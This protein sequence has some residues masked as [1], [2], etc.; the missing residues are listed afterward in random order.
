MKAG[1]WQK[2]LGLR[3]GDNWKKELIA[4][5]VSYFSVVYIVMVNANI[6]HDAGMPLKAAMIGTILTSIAGCLLMAFGGKSPIVVV[7]GMGINAFFTY[8]LV[9]SMKLGWQEALMV[10]AVTGVLFTI[11]TFTSLYR[12]ISEAI[13][14]NLQHGITVGIGLFL[15]FI[16]LQKS[17]IVIAHQTTFVTIG[18]FSDPSVIVA[19]ITLLLALILFIRGVQGGLLI[20]ILAGTG[21]AYLLGAVKPAKQMESGPIFKQYGT[22]FGHLSWSGFGSLVF[23]IAVFLLLLIVVFENIGLIAAQTRMI[24]RPENFKGSLRAL[25]LTNIFAGIFGSSPVVA[26]AETTAGIAAGGRTGLSSLVSAVLFGATFFFIPL[27][28]YIPD[29]AI[30][31]ILIVIGGLMVQNVKEM[32]FGDLT[33]AFPAFLIMVMIPFTYS[34]VDGMAFGFIAYP[35]VKLARGKGREVSPVLYGIAALFVANFVL[36]ALL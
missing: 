9:H 29:S 17:E 8:T 25:S 15:T 34:I 2:S 6:L 33:E 32:D 14:Q 18:H 4:G 36:H 24:G 19:C 23:W 28:A 35:I 31:P 21:L 1:F 13:P 22:I 20:S 3:P 7:P 11:V 5:A 30:A 26:A 12:I 16:G 27:L 10:V